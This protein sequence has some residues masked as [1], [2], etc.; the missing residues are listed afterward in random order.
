MKQRCMLC[1]YVIAEE[2]KKERI[3]LQNNSFLV[4]CPFWAVWPFEVM[5]LC[6]R[7]VSSLLELNDFERQDLADVLRRI[8]CRYDNLFQTSFPYSMG[9]HQSPLIEEKEEKG[10][11]H[12][13]IHFYPP[14]LRSA[15][16][17][18]FLVGYVNLI[19]NSLK[20]FIDTDFYRFEMLGEPQRD[21]TSEQ[22]AKRL[23]ELS[24][25]H[26]L[27][28]NFEF[29]IYYFIFFLFF[30]FG[31]GEGRKEVKG[32]KKLYFKLYTQNL[33]LL[34]WKSPK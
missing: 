18:K 11:Q 15:T 12:F 31:G 22:A 6:R 5:V 21:L 27:L 28:W 10:L 32:S 20:M 23:R 24:E 2:S 26:Y 16:V 13:H 17:R 33:L 3:V 9:I 19:F 34:I 1:D 14:L 4:V 8:C 29:I 30:F 25:K 7:H